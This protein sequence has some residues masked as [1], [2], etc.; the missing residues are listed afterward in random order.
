M[1]ELSLGMCDTK[2]QEGKLSAYEEI[3]DKIEKRSK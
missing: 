1:S 3:L 2:F